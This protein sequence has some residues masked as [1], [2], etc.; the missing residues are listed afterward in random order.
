M[1]Q[2][3]PEIKDVFNRFSDGIKRYENEHKER[4]K[5]DEL[6]K[7]IHKVD[8][9]ADLSKKKLIKKAPDFL[10][11][12][13]LDALFVKKNNDRTLF[14]YVGTLLGFCDPGKY[15]DILLALDLLDLSVTLIDDILDGAEKRA[16]KMAHHLKWGQDKTIATAIYLKGLSSSAVLN[17]SANEKIKL[18]LL[19]EMEDFHGKIYE[20]QFLDV[21]YQ[22]SCIHK[23]SV[24]DYL[25]MVSLT[26]GV[27]FAGCL[28]IGGILT[29]LNEE[30]INKLGEIGLSFG[31]VGQIRDDVIDYILDEEYT[32]KTPLLDFRKNKKRLPLII[33]WKNATE[34]ERIEIVNLQKKGYFEEND[35]VKVISIIM[36]PQNLREI[37]EVI[38]GIEDETLKKL[39]C[40]NLNI[41]GIELIKMLFNLVQGV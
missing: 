11:A 7:T 37:K 33:A 9:K 21:S 20:G 4:R 16:A 22:E 2:L 41:K 34:E 17:S 25:K 30:T 26:T 32:W 39:D 31:T 19:K 36:R 29:N 28:K 1:I 15:F 12:S 13:L 3:L 38:D 8:K 24:A 18:R 35:Y 5:W 27:Q 6:S 14:G 23:V 40:L 10:Q